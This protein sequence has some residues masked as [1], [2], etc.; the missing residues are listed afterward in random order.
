MAFTHRDYP[1][2]GLQ[3]PG[4]TLDE[5]EDP[6]SDGEYEELRPGKWTS[7]KGEELIIRVATTREFTSGLSQVDFLW[8]YMG[9]KYAMEFVAGFVGYRQ[10]AETLS[11]RPE[12]NWA[13]VDK[14]R[15]P[16]AEAIEAY[17][18][19]G[20]EAYLKERKH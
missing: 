2:A 15:K 14:Q 17:E 13:I 8:D 19:G 6:L 7:P 20:S 4:G 11:L 18:K 1:E 16:S 5:G 9:T 12:V 10:D 3:V